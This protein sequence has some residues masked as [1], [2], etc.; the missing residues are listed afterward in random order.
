MTAKTVFTKN[1]LLINSVF[2]Q[3]NHEYVT[4][5][6][7][8]QC[9]LTL[10]Y[11]AIL[12]NSLAMV[13]ELMIDFSLGKFDL[14]AQVLT[15]ETYNSLSLLL[16]G[17]QKNA[18]LFA[19]YEKIRTSIINALQGLL[20]AVN[21]YSILKN[22][23]DKLK[24]TQETAEILNDMDK[25]REYLAKLKKSYSVFPEQKYNMTVK[26]TLKPQY[27]EYIKRYGYPPGGIFEM[28]R[29]AECIMFTNA[30]ELNINS[31]YNDVC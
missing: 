10:S 1:T 27:T 25:L 14:V 6:T 16:N 15:M 11:Y 21:Q 8:N 18:F 4:T 26:A 9:E 17:L 12:A 13:N 29:L 2:Q 28:N 23:E 31:V 5:I 30:Q 20:Q 19:D 22:T 3:V 24:V 7:T